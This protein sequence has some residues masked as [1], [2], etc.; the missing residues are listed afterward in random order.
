MNKK[1]LSLLLYIWTM[2]PA[3]AQKISS[4]IVLLTQKLVKMYTA[5]I[6]GLN[7][8]PQQQAVSKKR[9]LD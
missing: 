9:A 1:V 4:L 2:L 8:A 3:M 5:M 7:V 6:S